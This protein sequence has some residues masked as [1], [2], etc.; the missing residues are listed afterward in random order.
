MKLF[1]STSKSDRLAQNSFGEKHLVMASK[2]E[3][4]A[5]E[6]TFLYPKIHMMRSLFH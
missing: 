6:N 5:K 2:V 1:I 4:E 3:A